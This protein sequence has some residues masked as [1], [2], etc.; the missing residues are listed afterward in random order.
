MRF[1]EPFWLQGLWVVPILGVALVG[2]V[3]LRLRRLRRLS[4][5]AKVRA[6]LTSRVSLARQA[7]AALLVS[8]ALG[9]GLLALARPQW[10]TRLESVTRRGADVLIA[11]DTSRSMATPDVVPDR[12]TRARETLLAL[13]DRLPA[14]RLGVTAFAGSALPLCPLTIDRT[15]AR[16]FVETLETGLAPDPGTDLGQAI[17]SARDQFRRHRSRHQALILLTDGENLTGNPVDEARA[18]AAEGV[19][20]HAVGIGTPAGQ[21]I[22]LRDPAGELTGYLRDRDGRPVISRLDEST[23]I[24]VTRAGGGLYLPARSDGTEVAGL[25]A[26]IG[27]MEADEWETRMVRQYEERFQWPLGLA[28]ACLVAQG[29]LTDRQRAWSRLRRRLA[30]R[31]RLGSTGGGR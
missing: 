19:T 31:F 11:V 4:A 18:A 8:A 13:I 5:S 26:A 22:P 20:L 17:R 21:P 12:L 27:A 24:E 1:A 2:A 3:Y 10:G 30:D 16:M 6:E 14:G 9:F 28:L 7:A 23:L 29:L 25:V 15:A